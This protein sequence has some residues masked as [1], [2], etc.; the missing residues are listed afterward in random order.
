[1]FVVVAFVVVEAFIAWSESQ[2]YAATKSSI[3]CVVVVQFM[4][5]K[6]REEGF[7]DLNIKKNEIIKYKIAYH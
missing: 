3:R 5:E 7:N 2:W 6:A 4:N 1:M